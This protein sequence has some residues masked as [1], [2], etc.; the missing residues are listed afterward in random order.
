[1]P[2]HDFDKAIGER[3]RELRL[4]PSPAVWEGVAG[5]LKE[6]RRKR[7]AAWFF[8]AATIIALTAGF[9]WKNAGTADSAENDIV[10]VGEQQH[11]N[12]VTAADPSASQPLTTEKP[13]PQE[14][15][16]I[17]AAA[18]AAE[19]AVE[20]IEDK[21]AGDKTSVAGPGNT[22]SDPTAKNALPH[23]KKLVNGSNSEVAFGS[24]KSG[25]V[26]NKAD[27]KRIPK[28]NF[29]SAATA[30]TD[31]DNTNN[32]NELSSTQTIAS[33]NFSTTS[34][35]DQTRE[36][37]VYLND[38]LLA[39]L[40][41]PAVVAAPKAK[42]ADNRVDSKLLAQKISPVKHR[43]WGY[44]LDINGGTSSIHSSLFNHYEASA[45]EYQ[46]NLAAPDMTSLVPTNVAFIER[47]PSEMKAGPALNAGLQVNR[48]ISKKLTIGIGL[49][50]AYRST[51]IKLGKVVDSAAALNNSARQQQ[52]FAAMANP[53]NGNK[54][55]DFTNKYHYLQVPVELSWNFDN[56]NRW[57][58]NNG[59]SLG[60]LIAV[61]ALQYNSDAG[62]YFPNDKNFQ[63]LQTGIFSS[64]HYT[65]NPSSH[66]QLSVGP[67][68][69][70]QL[71]DMDKSGDKRKMLF[72]GLGA[73]LKFSSK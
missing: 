67:S 70:Y 52:V 14:L 17:P 59:I 73:R 12:T 60:Y 11:G 37:L 10:K 18:P 21:N 38:Q 29:N 25:S 63:K 69:Q 34:N 19:L 36:P 56:R 47:Q 22:A 64:V 32:K 66:W 35:A 72:I 3:A 42:K 39:S 50:Y 68:A 46:A 6:K 41:G 24:K 45:F 43:R 5:Q 51:N 53:G 20:P 71:S 2:D 48:E 55:R 49:Q 28:D 8:L 57:H 30:A 33:A 13:K 54:G 65:I 58:W 27:K 9:W 4:E 1:M 31:N 7:G 62:V 16:N 26:N 44:A 40:Y 15:S 61:S 23:H